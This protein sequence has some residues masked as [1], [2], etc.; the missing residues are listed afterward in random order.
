MQ[1]LTF[2]ICPVLAAL[3]KHIVRFGKMYLKNQ[4]YSLYS[5]VLYQIEYSMYKHCV[6]FDT[7]ILRFQ[8]QI[9]H[10]IAE[11]MHHARQWNVSEEPDQH[12]VYIL[13]LYIK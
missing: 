10:S 6:Q 3:I 9:L 8:I 4:T 5:T 7:G 11:S 2:Q 13:L 12:T 1:N